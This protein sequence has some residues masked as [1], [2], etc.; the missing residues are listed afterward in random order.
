MPAFV[1]KLGYVSKRTES[2]RE[3]LEALLSTSHFL[4]LPTRAEVAG[5]VFCEASAFGLPTITTDAGG[6]ADYVRNS[7]NGVRLPLGAGPEHYAREILRI[8]GDKDMYEELCLS[9]FREFE[10]RLNW[11][12]S[13]KSLVR[14]MSECV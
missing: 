3:K 14:L 2:G 8:F 13:V 6:V 12:T 11:T 4:I 9:S 5:I 1:E 10:S 7:V